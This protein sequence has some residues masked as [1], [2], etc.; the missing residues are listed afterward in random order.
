MREKAY[1]SRILTVRSDVGKASSETSCRVLE[2]L[3]KWTACL[4]L[5]KPHPYVGS[6]YERRDPV[7]PGLFVT[8]AT[9]GLAP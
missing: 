4:D 1:S 3:G 5:V 8:P 6:Q 7:L 9:V 2:D